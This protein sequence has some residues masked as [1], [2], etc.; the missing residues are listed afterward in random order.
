M[1]ATEDKWKIK[2]KF[3]ERTC[4]DCKR[5]PCIINQQILKCDF[6]KYGCTKYA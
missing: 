5:Y 3:P 4:K 2:F 1:T 6:A